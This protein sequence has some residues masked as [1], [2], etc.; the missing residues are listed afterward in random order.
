MLTYKEQR[1]LKLTKDLWQELCAVVGRNPGQR[2]NDLVELATALHTI[3]NAI[4]A[5]SAAREYP[6]EYRLLGWALDDNE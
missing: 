5:N 3:Q 4:L 1:A 2:Q 6:G